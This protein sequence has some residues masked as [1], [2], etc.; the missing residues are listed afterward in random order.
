MSVSEDAAAAPI[1]MRV[2]QYEGVDLPG[3]EAEIAMVQHLQAAGTLEQ[4][5][6]DQ[7]GAL[8]KPQLHAGPCDRARRRGI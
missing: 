4:A 5:A 3:I 2:S 1:G 6:I 8:A 7:D